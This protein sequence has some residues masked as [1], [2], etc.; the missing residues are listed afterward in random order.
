MKLIINWIRKK[1]LAAFFVIT[2]AITWGLGFSYIAV[3]QHGKY[4]LATLVSIATCG[5]ALAGILVTTIGNRESRSGSKK[6]RWIAFLITQLICTAVYSAFNFYINNVPVSAVS[7]LLAFLL[8]TP[9]VAYVLLNPAKSYRLHFNK[10]LEKS[11]HP[12]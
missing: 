11:Y 12:R 6:A 4:Q 8:L 2:F 5:P 9:P 1:P 3:L 10:S 7:V